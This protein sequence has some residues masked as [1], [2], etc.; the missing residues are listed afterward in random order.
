[1]VIKLCVSKSYPP[2]IKT[3]SSSKEFNPAIVLVGLDAIESLYHLTLFISLT[4]SNLCLTPWNFFIASFCP[5]TSTKSFVAAIAVSLVYFYLFFKYF[6]NW[7]LLCLIRPLD[8]T[9]FSSFTP[10]S[11][12][13]TTQVISYVHSTV[14]SLTTEW[15]SN[16]RWF[17]SEN[18]LVNK[19][20]LY[21]H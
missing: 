16:T 12:G 10:K 5:S 2:A 4:N 3:I 15:I 19:Q 9:T 20:L 14:I 21:K 11:G 17:G 1:M 18:Y 6:K 7:C 8:C 13:L